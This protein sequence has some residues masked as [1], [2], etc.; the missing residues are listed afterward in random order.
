MWLEVWKY[1]KG[2]KSKMDYLE[3]SDGASRPHQEDEAKYWAE[4]VPGGENYG[5]TVYWEEVDCPPLDWLE[6]RMVSLR[7]RSIEYVELSVKL[8]KKAN[9]IELLI[10]TKGG[11][12][13]GRSNSKKEGVQEYHG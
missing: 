1:F 4:R 3:V 7:E 9:K 10:Q 11:L 8:R 2:G 12:K 5:W 13:N 6:K